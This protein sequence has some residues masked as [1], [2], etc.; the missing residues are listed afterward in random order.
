MRLNT[1]LSCTQD[2]GYG[3]AVIDI[4]KCVFQVL[5]VFWAGQQY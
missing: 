5:S 3:M 1:S 2:K 4:I